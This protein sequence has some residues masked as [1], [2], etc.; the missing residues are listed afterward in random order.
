[1]FTQK[2]I[3]TFGLLVAFW[4]AASGGYVWAHQVR[5]R[6]G[7]AEAGLGTAGL[8]VVIGLF[9]LKLGA[10]IPSSYEA[11]AVNRQFA[12][13]ILAAGLVCGLFSLIFYI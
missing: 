9:I 7:L 13:V 4:A 2:I 10:R 6:T 12:F 11:S 5:G 8:L 1:M 3:G